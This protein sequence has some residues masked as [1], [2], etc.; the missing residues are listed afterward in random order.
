MSGGIGGMGGAGRADMG[1]ADAGELSDLAQGIDALDRAP[2]GRRIPSGDTKAPTARLA[3][4]LVRD[5]KFDK[6]DAEALIREASDFGTITTHERAVFVSLLREHG[7]KITPAAMDVL[8]QRFGV[9]LR[10]PGTPTPAPAPTP[11][12]APSPS[13]S[14]APAPAPVTPP[15]PS[16][17]PVVVGALRLDGDQRSGISG[18]A[19]PGDSIEAINL[20]TAPE[21][22]LH[23]VD[24]TV[25]GRAGADGKFS[26]RLPDMKEG[27][28]VRLRT[29]GA[30]GA[31]G[32]WVTIRVSGTGQADTRNAPVNLE[33]MDL[34]PSADG[35]IDVKHNTARPLS[36]PG[37]KLRFTNARTG[38]KFDV[39]VDEKGSLPAGFKLKGK[40]GDQFSVAASDGK[41]NV[42][43]RTAAGL[44]RAPGGDGSVGGIDLP[45]PAP[46][47]DD[48][49][50]DGTSFPKTRF[51]GPLFIDGPTPGDVRQG[52]IGNCYFPAALAAVAHARPDAIKNAIKDN[53]DGTFTVRFYK[54]GDK[55]SP[56]DVKVD[57]DLYARSW[58]G[59]V[60]GGSLG[61]STAPDKMELWFPLIEK[62]YAQWKGGYEAIGHGGVSGDVMGEIVGA[63]DSYTRLASADANRIFERIK[64]GAS[65]DQPMTAGTFG[66][67]QASLYTNSGVYANHAYSV[68]GAV[69]EGGKKYV[70]IRN[71][72]GQSE[73]G[74][75]GKNDGVFKLELERFMK[76]YQSFSILDG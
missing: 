7:A 57:A 22:R 2:G 59:P 71:P 46:L 43:F 39:T 1:S 74:W 37:A 69:E 21:G 70:Q 42:D 29:R 19:K 16:P 34:V 24:T 63:T 12:P 44:L 5:G 14:P 10:R 61:G 62:A 28:V 53:G 23:L 15:T 20:T 52:A 30:D 32:E 56:V 25:I 6:A 26:G 49:R 76:L 11:T 18:F 48:V 58:G 64:A 72:W 27:D 38:E 9:S 4:A 75:D 66:K 41:N 65:K 67:D 55:R 35:T 60:Y 45:D 54:Y 13:P 8:A 40:A 36:E 33:R 50:T 47:K 73:P 68:L 51:T 3:A 31:E 17:S